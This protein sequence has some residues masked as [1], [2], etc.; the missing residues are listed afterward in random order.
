MHENDVSWLDGHDSVR[1]GLSSRTTPVLRIDVPA[2]L[3]RDVIGKVGDDVTSARGVIVA[4]RRAHDACDRGPKHVFDG[5]EALVDLLNLL[6][7]AHLRKVNT[8]TGAARV[9]PRVRGDLVSLVMD[10]LHDVRVFRDLVTNLEERGV[11]VI[12]LENVED[13]RGGAGPGTIIK[14]QRDDFVAIGVRRVNVVAGVQRV[15]S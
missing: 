10:A 15:A 1:N 12:L 13:L 3:G 4:A 7:S 11:R 6:V 9:I 8:A 5:L 2:N 14:R